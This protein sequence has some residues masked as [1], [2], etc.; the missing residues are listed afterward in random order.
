MWGGTDLGFLEDSGHDSTHER[1]VSRRPGVSW[2]PSASLETT[3]GGSWRL[4][5]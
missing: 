2:H 4:S 3:L 1:K 5:R